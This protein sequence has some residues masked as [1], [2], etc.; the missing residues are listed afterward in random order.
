MQGEHRP[1]QS[2]RADAG[3]AKDPQHVLVLQRPQRRLG[4]CQLIKTKTSSSGS[5]HIDFDSFGSPSTVPSRWRFHI[6]ALKPGDRVIA[7]PYRGEQLQSG[8]VVVV[9][10]PGQRQLL[11]KRLSAP[12]N[13]WWV[14]GD[15]QPAAATAVNWTDRR[16]SNPGHCHGRCA[17]QELNDAL[18]GDVGGLS[19]KIPIAIESPPEQPTN[20][21]SQRRPIRHWQWPSAT[22]TLSLLPAIHQVGDQIAKGTQ[23]RKRQAGITA[24]RCPAPAKPWSKP[25]PDAVWECQRC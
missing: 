7:T 25:R 8:A 12:C 20:E 23:W 24:N 16:N 5:W 9:T 18:N 4:H 10:H 17:I 22:Q 6:P 3:R 15:N 11:I 14:L 13:G 2:R 19:Q 1:S 21:G